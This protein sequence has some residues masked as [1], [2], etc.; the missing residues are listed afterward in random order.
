MS[1]QF[2]CPVD[3]QAGDIADGEKGSCRDCPVALALT[4][5]LRGLER[6][7]LEVQVNGVSLVFWERRG[8]ETLVF[9]AKTHP[10]LT[11]W[12]IEFDHGLPVRPFTITLDFEREAYGGAVA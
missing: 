1:E 8:G 12:I 10:N 3:V 2:L 7:V 11:D 9:T 5:A 6:D 4:R